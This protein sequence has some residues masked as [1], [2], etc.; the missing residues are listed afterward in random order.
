MYAARQDLRPAARSQHWGGRVDKLRN[1][2]TD[3]MRKMDV[4][5]VVHGGGKRKGS[6]FT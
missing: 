1:L 5:V 2:K 4:L 6:N 3:G